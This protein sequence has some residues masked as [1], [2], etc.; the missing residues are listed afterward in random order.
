M[1]LPLRVLLSL[2]CRAWLLGAVCEHHSIGLEPPEDPATATGNSTKL[3]EGQPILNQLS[4]NKSKHYWYET[5]NVTTMNQ[6]DRYRKLIISLEPCEGI[7]YIFVRRTRPCWP[8]PHS[9]CRPDGVESAITAPPCTSEKQKIKCSWTHYHSI[10]D[11]SKDGAPTFFEVPLTSTKY[12][13][14]VFAPEAEN[15]NSGV[16][17]EVRYRLTMLTDIG[18]FPRP[19]LQGRLNAKQ[20]GEMSMELQWDEATFVPVGVSEL[21]HYYI[22][23]SLLLPMDD[24][25]NNAVFLKPSKIMNSVCGLENNA[26]KYDVPL[27]SARCSSGRCSAVVSGVLPK[28]RYMFN[29]VSESMRNFNSSY[30]GI[31]VSSDWKETAKLF[32]E[33][34]DTVVPLVGGICGT[35]FGVVV[36]GYLWIVKL[37]N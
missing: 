35:I 28:R 30:A 3:I 25:I 34:A 14:T 9:C 10:L 26:V 12:Y 19:G 27:T 16:T 29:V 22:Y 6:P 31:I 37:Y 24:K 7:V 20:V 32:G 13:I 17:R 21:K 11:G 8:D 4:L 5:F 18:A 15:I 2:L 33:S 1:L 36:M 23:S